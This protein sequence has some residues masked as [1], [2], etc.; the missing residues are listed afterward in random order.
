VTD[1]S[2]ALEQLDEIH[3]RIARS[4]VY[5]GWRSLPVALSGLAGLAA[6]WMQPAS[7][8]GVVEPRAWVVYW[9][10]TATAAFGIGCAHLLWHY[11][12]EESTTAKR[13]TE[14][15]LSQ[16]LPS[17]AAAAIITVGVM[18]LDAARAGL[19][20]GIWAVCFSLGVFAARP[21]LPTAA[22]LIAMYYAAAAVVLLWSAHALNAQSGWLV[23]GVFAAGQFMAAAVLYWS[24]ERSSSEVLHNE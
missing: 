12:K 9:L 16:F 2:R 15:V 17:L 8:T 23:G 24:L 22:T 1:V 19:L 4:N 14:E 11:L 3:S 18:R 10:G 5:R 13:R 21:F 7:A 20:P 6:A